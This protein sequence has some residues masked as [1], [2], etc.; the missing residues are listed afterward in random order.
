MDRTLSVR[1]PV[2]VQIYRQM[3]GWFASLV[4]WSLL[5]LLTT[6]SNPLPVF[7][8]VIEFGLIVMVS[9]RIYRGIWVLLKMLRPS[10]LSKLNL[11]E[12]C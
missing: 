5:G 4:L 11:M 2:I 8:A 1:M 9:L 6:V 7:F 12:D 10:P 3:I